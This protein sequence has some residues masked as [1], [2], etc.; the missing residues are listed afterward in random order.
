[1]FRFALY[2]TS[3]ISLFFSFTITNLIIQC[4]ILVSLKNS[5]NCNT[6]DM[7]KRMFVVLSWQLLNTTFVF[8]LPILV[9]CLFTFIDTSSIPGFIFAPMRSVILLLFCLNPTQTSLVFLI[10]NPIHREYIT[11]TM[12]SM[13]SRIR[14]V[15]CCADSLGQQNAI[16]A[17]EA[18]FS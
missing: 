9:L 16:M 5:L 7:S 2:Y 18:T 17:S 1:Y 8:L 12:Y 13:W 4:L 15:L 6:E 11:E 10:K 14:K 3:G